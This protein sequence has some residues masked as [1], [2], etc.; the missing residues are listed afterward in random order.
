LSGSLRD[1][2]L[3]SGAPERVNTLDRALMDIPAGF[4]RPDG[5]RSRLAASQKI[6]WPGVYFDGP[7]HLF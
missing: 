1:S 2:A 6:A 3:L 4:R 5:I 7:R